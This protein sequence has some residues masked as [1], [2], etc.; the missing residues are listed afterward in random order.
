MRFSLA[1]IAILIMML[2]AACSGGDSGGER[3]LPT[4][5]A[6]PTLA[7]EEGSGEEAQVDQQPTEEPVQEATA[8]PEPTEEAVP[9]TEEARVAPPITNPEATEETVGSLPF[10]Q[11]Q[12]V[13]NTESIL[14]PFAQPGATII[15]L[16][17]VAVDQPVSAFSCADTTCDVVTTFDP[18]ESVE[19]SKTGEEWVTALFEGQEVYVN[20]N[21]LEP[22]GPL[23]AGNQLPPGV[24]GDAPSSPFGGS[25]GSGSLPPFA[26]SGGTTGGSL[27]PF[28]QNTGGSSTVPGGPTPIPIPPAGS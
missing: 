8:T 25:T 10:A 16:W 23:T 3:V 5:M 20:I 11:P 9:A 28:A 12:T 27:P 26:Q 22:V 7:T 19:V 17:T 4:S 14:P 15:D 2:A 21:L 6:L 13:E 18:G 24:S 1:T